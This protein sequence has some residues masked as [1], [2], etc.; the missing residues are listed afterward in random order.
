MT[1]LSGTLS[2]DRAL[3]FE[4]TEDPNVAPRYVV[5]GTAGSVSGGSAMM[6][7]ADQ[8]TQDGSFRS[9][10]NGNTRLILGS[11]QTR[12][13]TFAMR[14]LTADQVATLTALIGHTVIYCDTYGRRVFGSFLAPQFLSIPNS[15][16]FTDVN[17]VIQTITYDEAV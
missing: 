17:L 7:K 5:A 8:F 13:Q 10:G 1:T 14:Q 2:M 3:L 9:Y 11:G 4:V 15:G 6:G 16:G 12:T